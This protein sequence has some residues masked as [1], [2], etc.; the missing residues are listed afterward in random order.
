MTYIILTKEQSVIPKIM[1]TFPN[2]KMLPQNSVLSYQLFYTSMNINQQEELM[3]NVMK[4]EILTVKKK[5]KINRKRTR[6]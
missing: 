5:T 1:K 2:E 3:K 6:L 4:T